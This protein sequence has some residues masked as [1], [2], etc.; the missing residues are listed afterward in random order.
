[1][2]FYRRGLTKM[3]RDIKLGMRVLGIASGTTWGRSVDRLRRS[4]VVGVASSVPTE[5]SMMMSRPRQRDRSDGERKVDLSAATIYSLYCPSLCELRPW[6]LAHGV[7]EADPGAYQQVLVRLGQR[8]ESSHLVELGDVTDLSEVTFEER[9]DRT[10]KLIE[11]GKR[12]LYQPV[13]QST[14]P[15][16]GAD[17]RVVGI[18]DF[19]IRDGAGYRVRDCKL[20]LHADE[21]HHPEILRQLELYGWRLRARRRPRTASRTGFG[22]AAGGCPNACLSGLRIC[23]AMCRSS[24]SPDPPDIE[25]ARER[26]GRQDADGTGYDGG[27]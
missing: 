20:S 10:R 7:Q 13:F 9:I 15:I 23:A 22:E 19:L 25:G 3:P 16:D 6:L 18:P 4:E 12:V 26:R 27:A 24:R 11:L 21:E 5:T 8:H 17:V 14:I 2:L 1:M